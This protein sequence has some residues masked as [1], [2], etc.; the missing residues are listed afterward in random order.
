MHSNSFKHLLLVFSLL[1]C[2][3][4]PRLA[5]GGAKEQPAQQESLRIVSLSPNVTETLYAL[6]AGSLLVGRSD[7]CNYPQEAAALPSVGTLYNP[8]LE[9]LLSLEPNLVISSAFVPEQFLSSV[10]KAGIDVLALETQQDFQGTY[11][12]IREI[13]NRVG[14]QAE[15]EL[16][17]LNMQNDVRT[18]VQK[19]EL[20]PKPTVYIV[21]DFGSFDSSAT[22]DTFLSEMVGLAG[23]INIAD[24]AQ[25]W[26]YSK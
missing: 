17:I 13:A 14:R 20:L 16:M 15:G 21:L 5:A 18:I 26:T 12:L 6:D 22:K 3:V 23:G 7:Y 10:Q 9:T 25:N 11:T 8:S 2:L 1:L 19:A 24:D 4:I